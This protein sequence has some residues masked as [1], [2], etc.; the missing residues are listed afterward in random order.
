M[1]L[2]SEA[3]LDDWHNLV[4]QLSVGHIFGN[5]ILTAFSLSNI[6]AIL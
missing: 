1:G 6:S 3:S 5:E 2:I 4:P